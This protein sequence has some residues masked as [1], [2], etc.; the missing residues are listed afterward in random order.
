[1]KSHAYCC[2]CK[3]SGPKLLS[4]SSDARIDFFVRENTL[5]P[6]GARCC[7]NHIKDG[8]I[9]N[10]NYVQS[11][12]HVQMDSIS[13]MDLIGKLKDIVNAI[14][15]SRLDFDSD[16]DMSDQDYFNLTGL[17]KR[18]F[19]DLCEYVSQGMRN[20]PSRS[21]KPS[22]GIFL[23][24]MKSGLPNKTMATLFNISKSSLR[25]AIS[26]V[27]KAL[28]SS[29]VPNYLGFEHIAK[30]D[31]ISDHT[32]PLAQFLFGNNADPKAILVIDGTYIYIQKSNNFHF[33]RRTYSVHK[34]RPLVKPM[35]ICSSSGYFIS[36]L[37]PYFADMKNNDAAILNHAMMRNADTIRQ[38][39]QEEDVFIVDRGFRDSLQVLEDLGIKA[40]MPSFLKKGEKQLSNEEAN[41]SRLVSKVSISETRMYINFIICCILCVSL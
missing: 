2:L 5:L 34:G 33:Q 11:Q 31:I 35:V 38:W 18:H 6:G 3:R 15:T 30:Q 37:G 41:S 22:L 32:R 36:I 29:F 13:I 26:S 17:S 4:I 39:V 10:G 7:P 27:R 1:M 12:T 14:P 9:V 19:E 20:T 40:Q 23:L 21:I 25:R 8:R 16:R 28:M 24:K